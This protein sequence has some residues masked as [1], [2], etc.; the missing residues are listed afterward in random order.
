[1][2]TQAIASFLLLAMVGCLER[3]PQVAGTTALCSLSEADVAW[4]RAME[5]EHELQA[6]TADFDAMSTSFAEDVVLMP[7]NHPDIVG[8]T[9]LRQWQGQFLAMGDDYDLTVEEVA[10]C[11]DLAYVRGTYSLSFTPLGAPQPVVDAGRWLHILRRQADGTWLITHDVFS[12]TLQP[13]Q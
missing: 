9:P 4:I 5:S 10:G 6:A 12:S 7:P 11:G 8:R 3:T 2:R 13:V 1:M